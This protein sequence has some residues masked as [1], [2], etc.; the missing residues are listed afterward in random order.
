MVLVGGKPRGYCGWD[1]QNEV[2]LYIAPEHRGKGI[3][4]KAMRLLLYEALSRRKRQLTVITA[5]SDFWIKVGFQE[6]HSWLMDDKDK[7][8]GMTSLVWGNWGGRYGAP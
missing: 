4:T 7:L 6:R 2:V 3:G 5:R 8:C 1:D